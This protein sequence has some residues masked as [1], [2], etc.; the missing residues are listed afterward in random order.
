MPDYCHIT[1][2]Q[3]T[4]QPTIHN[5]YS[6][7][8]PSTS[9]REW[10]SPIPN[11]LQNIQNENSEHLV[12]GDFNLHHQK[13]GGDVVERAHEGAKYL[14]EAIEMAT[15]QLLSSR[16]V[17]TR[18]KHGNR[19]ST[20][21]LTLATPSLSRQILSYEVDRDTIGSD[22]FAGDHNTK[23]RTQ[24]VSPAS[25]KMEFQEAKQRTCGIWCYRH[26]SRAQHP[27]AEHD[28]GG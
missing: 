20:L 5:I 21:D 13:W 14:V 24:Y 3:P 23:T 1:F 22:H 25:T 11:M 15:L 26:R 16:G 7:T 17:L 19:P 27:S 10:E 18:K 4:G 28:Y 2:Q 8:L 6:E 12:V 9:S